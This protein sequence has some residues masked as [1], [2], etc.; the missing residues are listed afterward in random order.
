MENLHTTVELSLVSLYSSLAGKVK[1]MAG[2]LTEEQFWRK[3]FAFGNG[4]GNLLQHLTGNLNYYVGTQIA[5]T[6]YVRD[7]K[8]EFAETGL[9]S[10]A[11]VL[12]RFE[13]AVEMVLRAI[14]AQSADD[15]LIPYSAVGAENVRNRLQ[16]VVRCASHLDHHVGQ[17]QYLCFAL[18]QG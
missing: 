16:M 6:G 15:W 3:P 13:D 5:G 10:K 17:M 4:F 1:E 18:K 9:R 12:R 2:P 11:E 7:R 14:R 8:R